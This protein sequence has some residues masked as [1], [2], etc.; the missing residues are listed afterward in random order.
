MA[1]TMQGIKEAKYSW[2]TVNHLLGEEVKPFTLES[3]FETDINIKELSA[4]EI[5]R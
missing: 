1:D 4:W 2:T 3:L 5:L